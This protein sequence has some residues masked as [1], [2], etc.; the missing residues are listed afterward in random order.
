MI[1]LNFLLTHFFFSKK[2]I[3]SALNG[4]ASCIGDDRMGNVPRDQVVVVLILG[5]VMEKTLF[6]QFLKILEKLK[7]TLARLIMILHRSKWPM[8]C[9]SGV[10]FSL[11]L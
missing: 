3:I 6:F 2:V 9:V 1:F 11:Y 5:D 7:F 10:C 8:M 4:P